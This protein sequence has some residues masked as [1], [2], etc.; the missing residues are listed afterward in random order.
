VTAFM[1][2]DVISAT[3]AGGV[4]RL[5]I[6]HDFGFDPLRPGPGASGVLTI[7]IMN[8]GSVIGSIAIDEPFP[9]GATIVRDVPITPGVVTGEFVAVAVLVSPPG[10]PTFIDRNRSMSVVLRPRD[11]LIEEA[12]LRVEDRSVDVEE[13]DLDLS[14][15]HESLRER[16]RGGAVRLAIENPFAVAGDLQLR[17]TGNGNQVVRGISVAAHQTGDVW[18]SVVLS[19]SDFEQVLDER[20]LLSVHGSV[21]APPEGVTVRPNQEIQIDARVEF[22]LILGLGGGDL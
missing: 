11:I 20:L 2:E 10:S 13:I 16:I 21:D 6:T 12:V 22:E 4:A 19:R 3:L 8:Q 14:D 7:A 15:I 5:E 18:Q 1:P 9:S 17:V